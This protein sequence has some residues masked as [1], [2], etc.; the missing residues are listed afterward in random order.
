MKFGILPPYRTGVTA[1]PAWMRTF[2][3]H[4]EACGFESLYVVD[5][6]TNAPIPLLDLGAAAGSRVRNAAA[7]REEER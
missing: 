4:A 6:A 7:K 2:A 5:G 3:R 1:D